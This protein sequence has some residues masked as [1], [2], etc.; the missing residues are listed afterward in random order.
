MVITEIFRNQGHADRYF[1]PPLA[2]DLLFAIEK[3]RMASVDGRI[4]VCRIGEN[5][6]A[7]R[8]V[9]ENDVIRLLSENRRYLPIDV[10]RKKIDVM[11]V[12]IGRIG[13]VR[14]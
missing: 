8:L 11:G 5:V 12:V 7:K 3:H 1:A 6:Y 10:A 4:V 13:D 2:G 9:V 14:T